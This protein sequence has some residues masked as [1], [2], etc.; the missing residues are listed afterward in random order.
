MPGA[1]PNQPAPVVAARQ[2]SGMERHHAISVLQREAGRVL[3]LASDYDRLAA[4]VPSCP[5]WDLADVVK[6]LGNVYNWVATIVDG[7]L[8]AP[9]GPEIPRRPAD[10]GPG[11]WMADRLDRVVS[12]LTSAPDDA[13]MWNFASDS[14]APV[15]F[16]WRRQVHET[17]IHRVDAE[18]ACSARIATLEPEIA[19]D[20][21]SE[22]LFLLRFIETSPLTDGAP[23]P[24]EAEPPA[25][26]TVHLHAT[27][28]DGA[29][30]TVDTEARTIARAHTK[31]GVAIRGTAW[32]LARWCWGRSVDG[33]IET[34]GDL[35]AAESWRRSV[36]P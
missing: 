18:L 16:W 2:T 35:Q 4:P 1:P 32:A 24:A 21:V 13:V 23:A 36:V 30:W 6:H 29:E 27:D 5:G 28:A 8:A 34:F 15:S 25:G 3:Q 12:V 20:N 26:L 9:P 33:E 22:L 10:M 17:A 11:D 19:A 7:R 31:S 14:P